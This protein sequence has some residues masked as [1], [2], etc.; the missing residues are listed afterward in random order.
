MFVFAEPVV[1]LFYK[2]GS[3]TG[4]EVIE[5]AKFMRLLSITIFS[6]G[7][8]AIVTRI[9]IAM[10]AVKQAFFYQVIL[11]VILIAAIWL[12]TKRY[13]AYGYPY[14]VILS[15]IINFFGMYFICKKYFAAIAYGRLLKYTAGIMAVN[16]TVSALLYYLLLSANLESFYKLVIGFCIYLVVFIFMSRV[17]AFSVYEGNAKK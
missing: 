9:F 8:N 3:F 16:L 11:N 2:R 5:S 1:E 14:G 10:Q 6:I 4:Q 7:I 12:F 17:K 13:G 15:N